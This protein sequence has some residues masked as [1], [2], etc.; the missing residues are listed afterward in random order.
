MSRKLFEEWIQ[1]GSLTLIEA[2]GHSL[3]F[4]QGEPH[5][6]MQLTHP[7]SLQR[8]LR[9]P[10]M[11]LGENYMQGGVDGARGSVSARFAHRD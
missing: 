2:D 10:Q 7:R 6:V 1:I 8:I 4:G 3:T 5:G 11:A 9:N